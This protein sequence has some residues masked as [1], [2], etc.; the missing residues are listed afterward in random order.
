MTRSIS[1]AAAL[2]GLLGLLVLSG[3]SRAGAPGAPAVAPTVP[4][5]LLIRMAPGARLPAL[6]PTGA[7]ASAPRDVTRPAFAPRIVAEG[8]S[9]DPL[10]RTFR[11]SVDPG[12][13]LDSLARELTGR[14]GVEY[15][16]AVHLLPLLAAPDD[17]EVVNQWQHAAIGAPTAWN[18][19]AGDSTVVIAI[20][21]TGIDRTHPDL[22]A[23]FWTNAAEAAGQAGVDDDGNGY[24]D[25]E[26]GYDFTDVPEILGAGDYADR[27]ADPSDDV[28]HGTWVAGAAA[29]VGNNHLDGAGTA[30]RARL[31]PLRA[32]FR[33]RNGFALGFLAEDDAAA[34]IVYAADNGADVL[35][36]SFGDVVRAPVLEQ[37]VRYA[38][39]RGALVVAAAGNSG[40][41]VPFYPAGLP[42]VLAV[43]ASNRDGS[44]ASFSTWGPTVQLLAPGS[45]VLTAELGGG[46]AA[47]SGTSLAAP[48]AAGAAA[49]LRS[50][51]HDW[52]AARVIQA[53]LNSST[54]ASGPTTAHGARR[55]RLDR[56]AADPGLAL[57]DLLEPIDGAAVDR[58]VVVRGSVH[59]AGVR[60][61]RVRARRDP[62]EWRT[63]G[64][65]TDRGALEDTLARWDTGAEAEGPVTIRVEALGLDEVLAFREVRLTIDHTAPRLEEPE[66]LRVLS[67][68]GYGLRVRADTDEPVTGRLELLSMSGP[69]FFFD[70]P[71]FTRAPVFGLDGPLP[72]GPAEARLIFRN[73]A[74]LETT[75]TREVDIPESGRPPVM[76]RPT[77]PAAATWLPKLIDLDGDGVTDLV[78]ESLERNG[79]F[80]GEIVAWRWNGATDDGAPA[81]EETWRSGQRLIPQD[82]GD[83]DGDG[84]L[85]LLGLGL[86]EIWVYSPPPDGGFP[87][88][89][90]AHSPDAWPARFIPAPDGPGSDIVGSREE[91]VYVYRKRPGGIEVRQRLTNPTAGGNAV[92]PRIVALD[93]DGDGRI[94]LATIDADGDLLLWTRDSAGEFT[95]RQTMN[96][97]VTDLELIAAGDLDG[98]GRDEIAVVESVTEVP[99]PTAGLRDGFYRLLVLR[100]DGEGTLAPWRTTGAAG[101]FPANPVWIETCD[102]DGDGRAEIWWGI[103]GRLFRVG[104]DEGGG[105]VQ[106]GTWDGT[107][108]GRPALG[109]LVAPGA[110]RPVA[111]VLPM[112]DDSAPESA[113]SPVL[114]PATGNFEAPALGL[115]ARVVFIPPQ[116]SPEVRVELSWSGPAGANWS[117]TRRAL[118]S[119]PIV[120]RSWGPITGTSVVDSTARQGGRYAYRV[121]S[122]GGSPGDSL[123]LIVEIVPR[124]PL[125]ERRVDGPRLILEWL[126]PVRMSERARLTL[127]PPDRKAESMLLDQGG[128]RLT[129]ALDGHLDPGQAYSLFLDGFVSE[130]NLDLT[131]PDAR[132]EFVGEAPV[133]PLTLV[134]ARAEDERTVLLEFD[135]AAPAQWS[136]DDFTIEP[137]GVV[138]SGEARDAGSLRLHLLAPLARGDYRV[139][140]SIDARGPSGERVIPGQGDEI[141]LRLFPVL[142][143][144]PVRAGHSGVRLEWLPPGAEVHFLTM[145]GR[146]IWVGAADQGGSLSWDL[147]DQS[148]SDVAPG[149]Y[150]VSIKGF[151]D[152]LRKLAIIR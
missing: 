125:V 123:E 143:P 124:N 134:R 148:G 92:T 20:I 53:M 111:L 107:G 146:E 139:R 135:P 15:V 105:L 19:S 115:S 37:A 112:P 50:L 13:D 41:D 126:H 48:V 98:D 47:K 31:M 71:L 10:S 127:D 83:F 33:P 67:G 152:E 76:R 42:G 11:L 142:Y 69:E 109:A 25:D 73:Q 12:A 130:S 144:N 39:D 101:Q 128:R 117:V 96:V 110:E 40:D 66:I 94:T 68:H 75:L 84:R 99:S 21:D 17:P 35:N 74:G 16:S 102:S 81:F 88:R 80:Y 23:N 34:A 44:R 97:G 9:G 132:A 51:H 24:V 121:I 150:L 2:F 82:T 60:G 90:V 14:P 70:A 30:W 36:L 27:D 63:I 118:S 57:I 147:K 91:E 5:R 114:V 49:V 108:D 38:L 149:V 18:S 29:A 116:E 78:G 54:E 100:F 106:M 140:V 22:R 72:P 104:L 137:G 43:G 138:V 79:S 122:T 61:W 56:A 26:Q 141:P 77:A 87:T 4:G 58:A 136:P 7:G 151:G 32:G 8:G 103:T 95:F 120:D 145:A 131:G 133:V 1:R 85:D 59:G 113:T 129:V 89:L 62:G 45:S 119:A 93:A 64:L 46:M 55:L 6:R 28:G 3:P 86:R 65:L 52:N